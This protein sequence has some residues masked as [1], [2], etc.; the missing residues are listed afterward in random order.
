MCLSERLMVCD[1]TQAL[2]CSG[3]Q[4]GREAWPVPAE[5]LDDGATYQIGLLI[6]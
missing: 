1:V 4:Q 6:S 3:E 5:G 2:D